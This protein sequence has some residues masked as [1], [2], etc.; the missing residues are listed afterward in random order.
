M[1]RFYFGIVILFFLLPAD[2]SPS[3]NIA[4]CKTLRTQ[5]YP[6]SP[7]NS[8]WICSPWRTGSTLVYNIARF[9]FEDEQ[10]NSRKVVNKRHSLPPSDSFAIV[11]IRHPIDACLSYL[12]VMA[13]KG[14]VTDSNAIND[15][16]HAY[17]GMC[18]MFAAFVEDSSYVFLAYETFVNNY[19]YILSKIENAIGICINPKDKE[20]VPK[21][22]CREN[23]IS[24]IENERFTNFSDYDQ[25][26]HFH[27]DHIKTDQT[28]IFSK[29][30]EE[31]LKGEV[32]ENLKSYKDFN[33]I[34][35]RLYK[36]CE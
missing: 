33:A 13:S 24:Y 11:T 21:I 17:Y 36:A 22:F 25:Q 15:A 32:V 2:A 4:E 7:F 9:L 6:I 8:V 19:S 31:W 28:R 30:E 16:V 1:K 29:S 20:L 18:K 27:G 12:R 23:V 26:T 5:Q 3:V 14:K 10:V 34:L 35:D